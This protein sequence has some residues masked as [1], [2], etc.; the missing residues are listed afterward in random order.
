[1]TE[2]FDAA[3]GL[4]RVYPASPGKPGVTPALVW[5]HGGGFRGGDLDMPEAHWTSGALAMRGVT[6][7]S[8]DYRHLGGGFHY[9]APS[10]DILT[11]W[12]WTVQ[13]ADELGIDVGR[14]AIGGASAGG[15]L[16]TGAV[17]RLLADDASR[18]PL[19]AGVFLAYPTL[20]ADQPAPD[21]AMRALL[22]ANPS[23]IHPYGYVPEM[24]RNFFGGP[25]E[26]APLAVVPGRAVASDLAGFPPVLMINSEIDLLRLSGEVFAETL[27]SAGIPLELATEPG[28]LHGHLNR[29]E[30]RAASDSIDR[31]ARWI[32]RGFVPE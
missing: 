8:V 21:A 2:P 26:D 22:D 12:A 9:P 30:E 25:V 23:A 31:V 1:M 15:N 6:V 11:A 20:L 29:P 16:V 17:L 13:H 27:V 24:Y 10:D 18:L 28:V 14:S 4:V 32:E 5:A 19:P 7:I 3:D